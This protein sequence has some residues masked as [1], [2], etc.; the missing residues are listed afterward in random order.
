MVTKSTFGDLLSRSV[1]RAMGPDPNAS[2]SCWGQ[3]KS[4]TS[5][6]SS[7]LNKTAPNTPWSGNKPSSTS[8]I[9]QFDTSM[10]DK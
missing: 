8:V 6:M 10:F 2:T 1:D 5:P 3:K 7:P 9:Q 4:F